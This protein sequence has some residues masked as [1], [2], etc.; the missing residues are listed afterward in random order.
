LPATR[1]KQ[2]NRAAVPLGKQCAKAGLGGSSVGLIGDNLNY[3]A[4]HAQPVTSISSGLFA[5]N[6]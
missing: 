4:G 6:V 2:K 5:S 3:R 1:I